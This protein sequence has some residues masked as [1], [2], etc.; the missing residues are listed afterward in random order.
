MSSAA[1]RQ[2]AA[3]GSN[4]SSTRSSGGGDFDFS[5][6]SSPAP[7]ISR[8]PQRVRGRSPD[9]G[10]SS[11]KKAHHRAERPVVPTQTSQA[12][13]APSTAPRPN[14]AF[15]SLSR[16][17]RPEPSRPVVGVV[18]GR[19]TAP[20]RITGSVW[21]DFEDVP[22]TSTPLSK[23][24]RGAP[25]PIAT[26]EKSPA[27]RILAE[28][29]SVGPFGFVNM[30]N[31]CFAAAVLKVLFTCERFAS[32]LH[33]MRDNGDVHRALAQVSHDVSETATRPTALRSLLPDFFDGQQHDA[34]EFLV[35]LLALVDSETQAGASSWL[36]SV[37]GGRSETLVTCSNCDKEIRVPDDFVVA[38]LPL[39]T[40]PTDIPTLL[41]QVTSQ[42]PAEGYAC[43]SCKAKDASHVRM[44]LTELPL[45]LL[46]TPLRFTPNASGRYTKARTPVDVPMTLT[47]SSAKGSV[48]YRLAAAACHLG[49]SRDSGHYIS[50]CESKGAWTEFDDHRCRKI[51][52]AAVGQLLTGNTDVVLLRYEAAD[53]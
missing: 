5:P 52:D 42:Q 20:P 32:T 37:F 16:S 50:Y 31:S 9:G 10:V 48:E 39:G 36:G 23:P 43:D 49:R 12:R 24:S 6:A 14:I 40:T 45:S 30:G 51:G 27:A 22:S 26:T 33:T 2:L 1:R 8:T 15:F 13:T 35:N 3:L 4:R 19:T 7:L 25:S 44:V 28:A 18:P 41:A 53:T 34:H 47:V 21:N 38:T 17:L 11:E 29:G 46:L